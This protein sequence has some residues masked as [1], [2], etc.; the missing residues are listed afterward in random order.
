MQF[1][2]IQGQKKK[3]RFLCYFREKKYSLPDNTQT[4]YKIQMH[5]ETACSKKKKP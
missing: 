5:Y 2:K 4:F 3:N 1:R